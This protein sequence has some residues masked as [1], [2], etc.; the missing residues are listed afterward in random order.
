MILFRTIE[1]VR[2]AVRTARL[3]GQSVGLVP[4]MGY[5]HAGHR[6]LIE[7]A[8]QENDRVIVSIFVNPTQFGPNEDFASYPRDLGRDMA[9]CQ[10]AGADWVFAPEAAA[11]YPQESLIMVDVRGL[12]DQLCG[13]RRPGHF[14]GVCLVVGKLFNIC[15]PDRAYFGEKDAQQLAII[16]Q[17]ARDL[18]FPVTIVGCPIVREADGLALSSRNTYL[19]EAERQAALVVPRTVGRAR[20]A[21]LAGERDANVIRRLMAGELAGEPLARA[22]YLELVDSCSLQ[23]VERIEASVLVA[24][25]IYVGQTR[26]IDNLTFDPGKD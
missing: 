5:L 8:R 25:A 13:A 3:Q 6:S 12:G 2:E 14:R 19:S 17:L 20:Q 23:P 26:L 4:T 21:L 18:N 16:R 10:G 15:Q 11:M 1:E 7:K 9:L 24:V 22:D